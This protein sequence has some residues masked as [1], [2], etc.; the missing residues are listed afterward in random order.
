[1]RYSSLKKWAVL[2]AALPFAAT[3]EETDS[4]E[5]EKATPLMDEV[6]VKADRKG[7]AV[8]SGTQSGKTDLP[9]K[10]VST[11]DSAHLL[12]D[13]PGVS[14]YGAGGISSLPVIH[15]LA[16]DRLRVQVDGMDLQSACPNHM[17]SPLSYIDPSQVEA[18]VVF[19]GITPV[20]VG[21]DSIGGTIQVKSAKPEFAKENEMLAKGKAG[22]YYRSNGMAQGG[23][24]SATAASSSINLTYTGAKAESRNYRAGKAYKTAGPGTTGGPWLDG[25]EVGSSAY[26]SSNHDL[27]LAV[28]Q[29]AHLVQLN[30]GLQEVGF[31]GFP[32]QRMDMTSNRNTQ[33]NLRYTGGYRWGGLEARAYRQKTRHGMNMGADRFSYGTAGM[34]METEAETLGGLLQGNIALTDEDILRVGAEYQRYTLN[35]W[36]PGVGGMMGPNAFWNI[37]FGTRDRFDVFGEWEASPSAEW[38]TLFGL[39]GDVV[40][41]GAGPVQ[42]YNA[43]PMWSTDAASFNAQQRQHTDHNWDMTALARYTP[44]V[45]RIF[46]VGYARKSHSPNLYQRYTWSTQ[47][48]AS[49]MNNF[50]GDGN[51][52]IGN[53]ALKP[54]VAHTLSASGDW[55]DEEREV[56]N[57]KMVAYYTYVQDYID[58]RRCNFGQCGGAANLTATNSFVSLQYVNQNARLY[59]FDLSGR[60]RLAQ[61]D[62]GSYTASAMLNHVRGKNLSTGDNLYNIMPTNLK[63]AL[64]QRREGWSNTAEVLGVAAKTN[65]SQVRN[66]MRTAGYGLFNL[67]SSYEWKPMRLDLAIENVFNRHYAA[68]LGGAYVGQGASMSS[69]SIPWGVVVPGM[70]RSWNVALGLDF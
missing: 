61:N 11:S 6:V 16:D 36:W 19:A 67:R 24:L 7:D 47:Q 22:A 15:G 1:M 12:Q 39:R 45:E 31:E 53:T 55:G 5:N 50:V 10:R 34:P 70:G 26:R 64:M 27:G 29:E 58:A 35:D 3:A 65:V 69:N 14:L 23:N 20:S 8:L 13:V 40:K 4:R 37:D 57:A 60:T 30:V 52:Y 49:L 46:D 25:S 43:V 51:A 28:K 21:G 33:V 62:A 68:P 18:V 66:E 54:E 44:D 9:G 38:L 41:S 56:W 17:N 42:G 2:L 63:L 32:N 48:M 59:G